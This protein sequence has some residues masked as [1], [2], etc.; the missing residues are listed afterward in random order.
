MQRG[1]RRGAP[2][3]TVS[4]WL[5]VCVARKA[6]G[7]HAPRTLAAHPSMFGRVPYY[8]KILDR[9]R[10]SLATTRLAN[11]LPVPVPGPI[12][13]LPHCGLSDG[14]WCVPA[15]IETLLAS[16][17]SAGHPAAGPS[18]SHSSGPDVPSRIRHPDACAAAVADVSTPSLRPR[19]K[20]IA[21]LTPR[22]WARESATA[23]WT[24]KVP[25]GI[26]SY[27]P[28]S[29]DRYVGA[30]SALRF[31]S[32]KKRLELRFV[33]QSINQSQSCQSRHICLY[34]SDH[35]VHSAG[36]QPH[37]QAFTQSTPSR[38]SGM[39]QPVVQEM[40]AT[41]HAAAG[42]SL[43]SVYS[44]HVHTTFDSTVCDSGHMTFT[45]SLAVHALSVP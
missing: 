27:R 18:V 24:D 15:L 29:G 45:V 5:V 25:S 3:D 37:S 41:V 28:R 30:P 19:R 2:S 31:Y 7:Q 17:D 43:F 1:M 13:P 39:V 23:P 32:P 14:S 35:I 42:S 40:F 8:Q 44:V 6:R 4:L 34:A 11:S 9:K 21:C 22:S 26:V 10:Y 36:S 12:P 20:K 16:G 38:Q 33:N